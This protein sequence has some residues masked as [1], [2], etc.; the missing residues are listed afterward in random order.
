MKLRFKKGAVVRFE[1]IGTGEPIYKVGKVENVFDD[2]VVL[3]EQISIKKEE[4]KKSDDI[5]G[6]LD[7]SY[8]KTR[9]VDGKK[10]HINRALIA[11]WE[12]ANRAIAAKN[13]V[14]QPDL[15]KATFTYYDENGYCFGNGVDFS[16]IPD[17]SSKYLIIGKP[18]D[19]SDGLELSL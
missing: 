2:E 3:V 17:S 16:N 18:N 4:E 9:S 10:S 13:V 12:Y 15:T 7:S 14:E 8:D 19:D 11:S 6:F 1:L 5:F